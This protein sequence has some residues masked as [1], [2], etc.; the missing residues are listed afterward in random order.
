M[1][2]KKAKQR[3]G[4]FGI[5][6]DDNDYVAE[7]S[8]SS[9]MVL[10]KDKV[11]KIPPWSDILIGVTSLRGVEM[12]KDEVI[13]EQKKLPRASRI[14]EEFR[15]EPIHVR[16]LENAE[17]VICISSDV[18]IIPVKSINGKVVGSGKPGALWKRLRRG[19]ITEAFKGVKYSDHLVTPSKNEECDVRFGHDE[20]LRFTIQGRARL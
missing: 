10:T 3:G 4:F 7:F 11:L 5:W 1:V 13:P 12:V 8:I 9:L 16:E 17:E 15:Q 19:I 2:L 20:T 6:L 14:V 18:W